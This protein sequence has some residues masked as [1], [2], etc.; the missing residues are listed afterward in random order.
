MKQFP[1]AI[2]QDQYFIKKLKISDNIILLLGIINEHM[3]LYFNWE[4]I[5][6]SRGQKE[7][8]CFYFGSERFIP[9]TEI[10]FMWKQL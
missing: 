8:Q 5:V 7:C 3:F 6:E 2:L 9:I 4:K 10:L 1:K